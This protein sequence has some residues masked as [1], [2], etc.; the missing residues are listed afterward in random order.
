MSLLTKLAVFIMSFNLF[1]IFQLIFSIFLFQITLDF[2]KKDVKN[3]SCL[4]V[5]ETWAGRYKSFVPDLI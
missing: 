5:S 2:L 3:T 4:S 1:I